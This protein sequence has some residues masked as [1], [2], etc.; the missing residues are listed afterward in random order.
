MLIVL[1][2]KKSSSKMDNKT[3]CF[4]ILYNSK[5]I[6]SRLFIINNKNNIKPRQ[7]TNLFRLLPPRPPPDFGQS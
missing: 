3:E 7:I 5:F 2:A 1:H 6:R 4:K